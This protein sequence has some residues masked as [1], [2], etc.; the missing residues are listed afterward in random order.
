MHRNTAKYV[1]R[2]TAIT[3]ILEGVFFMR[4]ED[5]DSFHA[6][7]HGGHYQEMDPLI[8]HIL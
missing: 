1:T 7:Y 4:L 8:S 5:Y 6:S 2:S 3:A